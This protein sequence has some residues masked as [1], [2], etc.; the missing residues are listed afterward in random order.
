M[1]LVVFLACD[2]ATPPLVLE[3]VTP[4]SDLTQLDQAVQVQFADLQA[5]LEAV[6]EAPS[7]A[8]G[9]AWGALGQW[10]HA[11][12]YSDSAGSCY[13]NALLLDSSE[14]KW[15][16]YAG[17]LEQ[18]SGRWETA[19]GYYR[20][21]AELAPT[22][23]G[24]QVRL[25]E[26]E[27]QLGEA[28]EA[29]TLFRAIVARDPDET[30]SLLGLARVA[31]TRQDYFTALTHLQHL[32]E[33]QPDAA[34]ARYALAVTLRQLQREEEAL[35][36][37]ALV[38][39]DNLDQVRLAPQ[40]P[41]DSELVRVDRGSRAL[42]RRGVRAFRARDFGRAVELLGRAVG[43]DPSGADERINYALALSEVGRL[44]A[45]EEQL[46]LG[47]EFSQ[48]GSE[49]MGK[50]H[51]E[52]GR[53][54]V[55]QHEAEAARAHFDAALNL[56]STSVAAH[57]ELGRLN[58]RQGRL[59]DALSHYESVCAGARPFPEVCFWRGALLSV[60]GR[61]D[62]ALMALEEDSQR[63]GDNPRL[64]TLL[65]RLL[66]TQPSASSRDFARARSLVAP[67]I[68][69][70]PGA[71]DVVVAQTLA[72]IAAAERDFGRAIAW[73]GSVVQALGDEHRRDLQIARR[74]LVLY[75]QGNPCGSPWERLEGLIEVRVEPP[76]DAS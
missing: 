25:A 57:T 6:P 38:P 11:Y 43:S 34:E 50:S 35:A 36:E 48:P 27:L 3:A 15:S 30:L 9:S 21:A 10:F 67:A 63:F 16:Y 33:L 40:G 8:S 62:E 4:P 23:L 49:L 14:P 74:R 59:E 1:S 66:V 54:A 7:V 70:T 72:M 19:R 75:R 22:E 69:G 5:A 61:G 56:D 24:P 76:E 41:W 73:Q 29:E 65:A 18:E 12:G 31:M 2:P 45:A 53:L 58:H 28:D 20:A 71:P 51:L 68:A 52:L 32:V 13:R 44:P 42:T 64:E 46:R 55:K 60:L 47:L 26:L 37:L 39:A 17:I